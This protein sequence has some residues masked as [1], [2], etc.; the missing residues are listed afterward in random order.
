[1]TCGSVFTAAAEARAVPVGDVALTVC[2]GCGFVFNALFDER[3]ANVGAQYE[4]SQGT[5]AHFSQYSRSLAQEWVG[6]H[7]LAGKTVLEV[8]CGGGE[9]LQQMLDCGVRRGIG[10]DPL[11][12]A[13]G[14]ASST[15]YDIVLIETVFGA[16][17]L[18]LEANALVCRHTLEHIRDTGKFLRQIREWAARCPGRV[19]LFEVP[20][21][22]RVLAERAFWDVYYEHCSYFTA[23]TL[24][25]AFMSAGFEVE[26]VRYV[27]GEQYLVLEATAREGGS[28]PTPRGV[29]EAHFSCAAFEKYAQLAVVRAR[30][31]LADLRNQAGPVVLWQ[32]A[33]K[34]VG[35]L[36][37]LDRA[38]LVQCAID[39]NPRRHGKFLPGSGLPVHSPEKLTE[40]EPRNV[41]LMNSIYHDEVEAQLRAMDLRS[42]LID[43][44]ELIETETVRV[45]EYEH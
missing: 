38:D 11:A 24:S 3:L 40:L 6:R 20:A 25:Y 23:E 44:D 26:N 19:V 30:D 13:G 10:V 33:S 16:D 29:S 32:G 37:A 28:V 21:A 36:T 35:F 15:E 27:Y 14:G 2:P 9:F 22:G 31:A 1:V 12:R 8:G 43:V 39:L 5:S 17:Q 7:G 45:E 4:S 42:R 41:V 34:T 18:A